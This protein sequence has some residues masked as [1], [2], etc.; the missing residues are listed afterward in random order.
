MIT[1]TTIEIALVITAIASAIF[2]FISRLKG[3]LKL[4]KTIKWLMYVSMISFVLIGALT[5]VRRDYTSDWAILSPNDDQTT[6]ELRIDD[7]AN[8]L[9]PSADLT[10][11]TKNQSNV[12]TLRVSSKDG[13]HSVEKKVELRTDDI[14]S[15]TPISSKS[16]VTNVV[17]RPVDGQYYDFLGCKSEK[18][19]LPFD[20]EIRLVV[21]DPD[22]KTETK[23]LFN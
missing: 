13:S 12:L 18:M 20:A 21:A 2:Y 7:G 22:L 14:I 5:I 6:M 9:D 11:L 15:V 10:A 17:Y 1:L 3:P 8:V 4:E 23:S 16:R 19:P